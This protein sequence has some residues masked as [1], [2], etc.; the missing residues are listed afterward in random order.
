MLFEDAR[1][2][3]NLPWCLLVTW[4]R[5]KVCHADR[6]K[7][8]ESARLLTA[9]TNATATNGDFTWL[10]QNISR[11]I[12]DSRKR[13]FGEHKNMPRPRVIIWRINLFRGSI[14]V[15]FV[16]VQNAQ[17]HIRPE[18]RGTS[19]QESSLVRKACIHEA[20][21]GQGSRRRSSKVPLLLRCS[22]VLRFLSSTVHHS[23]ICYGGFCYSFQRVTLSQNTTPSSSLLT[24]QLVS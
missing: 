13:L 9:Q 10:R 15:S 12:S 17:L 24:R 1:D 7:G 18:E 16:K 8:R 2:Q 20:S 22:T 3:I 14:E 23:D 4:R 11:K 21:E 5:L 19:W 6:K